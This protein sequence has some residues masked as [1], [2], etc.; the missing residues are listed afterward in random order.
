M[1]T[2]HT[3]LH[4]SVGGILEEDGTPLPDFE[5]LDA[6]EAAL[7]ESRA[8]RGEVDNDDG[9]LVQRPRMHLSDRAVPADTFL[10]GYVAERRL[11]QGTYGTAFLCRRTADG[12]YSVVKLANILVDD[13]VVLPQPVRHLQ[14]P[15]WGAR[16]YRKALAEAQQEL[17]TECWHAEL[18]L[19]P[20]IVRALRM[21]QYARTACGLSDHDTGV[22]ALAYLQNE[23]FAD[24]DKY[25]EAAAEMVGMPLRG[26]TEVE[27]YRV[28]AAQALLRTHPGFYHM[29]SVRHFVWS[30]PALVSDP[31][32]GSLYALVRQAAADPKLREAMT[33]R[34][35][36]WAP[37]YLWVNIATQIGHAMRYMEEHTPVAHL[38]LKPDNMLY[39]RNPH[40]DPDVWDVTCVIADFGLV[41]A[42]DE[43]VPRL[44]AA[45]ARRCKDL[46][47][48]PCYVPPFDQAFPLWFTGAVTARPLC[49]FQYMATMA[50]L[51]FFAHRAPS[52][53][54]GI[55]LDG[56]A[57]VSEVLQKHATQ[58]AHPMSHLMHDL[59][60][61]PL[62]DALRCFHHLFA[63]I[64]THPG[65]P[66]AV[67]ASFH[68]F[69]DTLPYAAG[70]LGA[71]THP[72][73]AE[74]QARMD[75]ATAL[76]QVAYARETRAFQAPRLDITEEELRFANRAPKHAML[77][78]A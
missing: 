58:T 64:I 55:R 12:A 25:D 14:E 65:D 1:S 21:R 57:Y 38:D 47:G 29:H 46:M 48:T 19:E 73:C 7:A 66:H 60:Q 53:S 63:A 18:L 3:G 56:A 23:C 37:P 77:V 45:N 69:V 67:S 6:V 76:L 20:A 62:A 15:T 24:P 30:I 8:R 49:E 40:P 31:L 71:A 72:A 5:N 42:H 54:Q 32:D 50:R 39:R 41:V 27:F 74:A 4:I 68:Q 61:P 51:L 13:T 34:A 17:R 70:A 28:M 11:G 9:S 75:R 2:R 10:D 26:L 59:S 16:K 78:Y 35:P 36:D 43:P 44:T 22:G 33:L 52:A